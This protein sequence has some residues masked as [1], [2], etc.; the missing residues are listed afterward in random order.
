MKLTFLGTSA[1]LPTKDRNTSAAVLK[2]ENELILIDCGEGTQRQLRIAKI[3]PT[4][5]TKILITHWHGDHVLGLPGLLQTLSAQEYNK[6]LEIYGPKET[7]KNIKQILKLFP[8]NIKI[9]IKEIK[10]TQE[11]LNKEKYTINSIKLD[12]NCNAIGYSF[13]EKDKINLDKKKLKKLDLKNVSLL[14]KL[15]E[16]KT[17]IYKNKKITTKNIARATKGRKISILGD[18]RYSKDFADLIKN[19][20]VLICESTFR[21]DLKS[22]ARQYY[23]LTNEDAAKI[24]K[25][26]KVKQLILTHFGQR[27]KHTS[28]LIKETK[29]IFQK[30]IA[31]K[32]FLEIKL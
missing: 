19:S 12:H 29:K 31:A 16:G 21:K 4:K 14:K 2:Y 8:V 32:D 22:K 3:S 26:G 13:I 10:K 5:I 24:A 25:Q 6:E 20:N 7:K 30:T 17:I 1:M 9:K 11:F 28:E 15:K 18:T 27:Y 23:H